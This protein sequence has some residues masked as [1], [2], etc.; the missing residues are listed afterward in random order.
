MTGDG[1]SQTKRYYYVGLFVLF[2]LLIAVCTSFVNYRLEVVSFQ[3]KLAEQAKT[4]FASKLIDLGNYTTGLENIVSA[5]RDSKLLFSFLD[6]P[7]SEKYKNLTSLFKAVSQANPALMQVRFLNS[8]GLEVV[9][10]DWNIGEDRPKVVAKENLQDK[11]QR[12]YFIE[13]S[14][15]LPLSMW[16][17]KLD[18]NIEN[19]KIEVPHKPVL[20]VA[21][22]VY[23]NQKFH[24]LVIINVHTKAFLNK[25]KDNALFYISLVDREGYFLVD[26]KGKSSWSR[27]LES[28]YT[29]GTELPEFGQQIL[30][31]E[32]STSLKEYGHLYVASVAEFFKKDRAIML[33]SAK[34]GA[35]QNMENENQRAALLIIAIIVV[36]SIPI[37]LVISIGPAKLFQTIAEKNI[38][39]TRSMSLIDKNILISTMDLNGNFIEGSSAFAEKLGIK[40]NQLVGMK[41]QELFCQDVSGKHYDPVWE[42]MEKGEEWTGE[43]QYTRQGSECFWAETVMLPKKSDSGELVG[44]SVICQD[45]TDKKIIEELSIT[46]VITGLYNRRFFNIMIEKELNRAKRSGKNLAFAMFDLDYFKQYNDHYGHQKGDRVLRDIAGVMSSKLS[47][48]S[49]SCFRLGGEEFGILFLDFS[50]SEALEFAETIRCAVFEKG[51]EHSWSEVSDVVTVSVGLLTVNPDDDVTVELI[52][53]LADEALYSAKKEG[54]NRIVSRLLNQHV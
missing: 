37:A 8:D 43:L 25:L 44:Y 39:L 38:A 48:A 33:L 18:L 49:D 41:Y 29:V 2:G 13:A 5:V 30:H 47:R 26:G 42:I 3:S 27:Y 34:Q 21:S 4:V 6:E 7:N 40:K 35:V 12:Y 23:I 53:R 52:Y 17:S 14:Q 45:V 31:D 10:V 15:T 11:G 9:R 16:Y 50:A 46:D 24:G 22:P 20:R 19:C 1:S 51:I 28:G 32:Q 54:R 36:L